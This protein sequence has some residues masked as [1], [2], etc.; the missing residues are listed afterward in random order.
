M[1]DPKTPS[2][3]KSSSSPTPDSFLYETKFIVLTF[4]NHLTQEREDQ[5]RLKSD[6]QKNVREYA[7][8]WKTRSLPSTPPKQR[9]R[10]KKPQISEDKF[11]QFSSDENLHRQ[12]KPESGPSYNS[13]DLPLSHMQKKFHK[14]SHRQLGARYSLQQQSPSFESTDSSKSS[15]SAPARAP[16][17]QRSLSDNSSQDGSTYI[18]DADDELDFSQGSASSGLRGSRNNEL[19]KSSGHYLRVSRLSTVPSE[20]E[21]EADAQGDT[22]TAAETTELTVD[23]E[24]IAFDLNDDES[25]NVVHTVDDDGDVV[26][27][28]T[29]SD[30]S[31]LELDEAVGAKGDSDIEEEEVG[32]LGMAAGGTEAPEIANGNATEARASSGPRSGRRDRLFLDLSHSSLVTP[33]QTDVTTVM[34]SL[35]EELQEEMHSLE[36]EVEDAYRTHRVT[37]L[38]SPFTGPSCPLTPH[39]EAAQILARIGDEIQE[40][41]LAKV[42]FAI[43]RLFNEQSCLTYETFREVARSVVDENIPGWRQVALLLLYSQGV[44]FRMATAGG[45]GISNVVDYSVKLLADLAADFIIQQ[46]GWSGLVSTESSSSCVT[47]PELNS[48][49]V[50]PLAQTEA[51][52]TAPAATSTATTEPAVGDDTVPSQDTSPSPPQQLSNGTD[53]VD[54]VSDG[55]ADS[56]TFQTLTS[57]SQTSA[58]SARGGNSD[59]SSWV[60]SMFSGNNSVSY[61]KKVSATLALVSLGLGL[62]F[63][64]FKR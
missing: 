31:D 41:H 17:Y 46:G 50:N 48:H 49:L 55:P 56:D 13:W 40:T 58:D 5:Q 1:S 30:L 23:V 61:V 3:D 16:V 20:S 7:R 34:A 60:P 37:S 28:F 59:Q 24:D 57:S 45:S 2:P 18:S 29:D 14:K 32:K 33:P 10:P 39:T 63:A 25:G 44:A 36:S 8:H 38:P 11:R 9:R 52:V 6:T 19:L 15:Q 22:S 62:A 27:G 54:I 43:A 51:P 4:L 21:P 47:S 26:D 35:H 64:F 42:E 53:H 12:S